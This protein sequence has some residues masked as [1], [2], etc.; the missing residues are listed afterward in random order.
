MNSNELLSIY[1]EL[2]LSCSPI[3]KLFQTMSAIDPNTHGS[4]VQQF[5]NLANAYKTLTAIALGTDP[6]KPC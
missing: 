3:A 5:E 2:A 6:L 4:L 1:D